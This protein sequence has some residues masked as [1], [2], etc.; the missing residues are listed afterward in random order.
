MKRTRKQISDSTNKKSKVEIYPI[1]LVFNYINDP[2]SFQKASLTCKKWQNIL[3]NHIFWKTL[4]EHL[5]LEEPRSKA[6]K[7]KTWKSIFVKNTDKLCICKRNIK[8]KN[9]NLKDINFKL[10]ILSYYSLNR[11]SFYKSEIYCQLCQ[12]TRDEL[13]ILYKQ[14]SYFNEHCKLCNSENEIINSIKELINKLYMKKKE[15]EPFSDYIEKDFFKVII[16]NLYNIID[17]TRFIYIKQLGG[18]VKN[19]KFEVKYIKYEDL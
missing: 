12:Y 1:Q 6:K 17:Y 2:F 18:V 9:S 8:T 10:G 5:D 4:C 3:D 14:S 19:W 15:I 16:R 13:E 7:Y 11:L